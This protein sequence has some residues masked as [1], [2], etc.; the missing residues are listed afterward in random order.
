MCRSLSCSSSRYQASPIAGV[1]PPEAFA[2]TPAGSRVT[3]RG[4]SGGGES[5]ALGSH[6]SCELTPALRVSDAAEGDVRWRGRARRPG[7]APSLPPGP[8]RGGRAGDEERDEP[9]ATGRTPRSPWR[10]AAR[11]ASSRARPALRRWRGRQAP[12]EAAQRLV[13]PD[14]SPGAVLVPRS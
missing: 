6:G 5:W 4:P 8:G 12:A 1:A 7:P 2:P 13:E 14:V 10:A 3:G 11:E 9:G